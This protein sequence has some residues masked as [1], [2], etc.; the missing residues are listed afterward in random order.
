MSPLIRLGKL[1]DIQ[2][3]SGI[4][5][6]IAPSNLVGVAFS[7]TRIDLT[8]NDNSSDE[9]DFSIERAINGGSF[10]VI[11]TTAPNAT[12]YSDT[13]LDLTANYY[14]YRVRAH[15]GGGYS[16]YSNT[17]LVPIEAWINVASP[18]DKTTIELD[19]FT[20]TGT[21]AVQVWQ[22]TNGGA[23]FLNGT[24][25]VPAGA[26]Y[27]LVGVS[28][29]DLNTFKLK[30][31][32][33]NGTSYFGPTNFTW[34]VDSD[35]KNFATYAIGSW[36]GYQ[37]VEMNYLDEAV[38]M[39][40]GGSVATSGAASI[41]PI[42]PSACSNGDS[43]GAL[44]D[45]ARSDYF[46]Y[47]T[48]GTLT[49]RIQ[50]NYDGFITS[51]FN[52]QDFISYFGMYM[53]YF[54]VSMKIQLWQQPVLANYANRNNLFGTNDGVGAIELFGFNDAG[55]DKIGVI[56]PDAV[57]N[58]YALQKVTSWPHDGYVT[59]LAGFD[60]NSGDVS[61]SQGVTDFVDGTASNSDTN[62]P[63]YPYAPLIGARQE[64][65]GVFGFASFHMTWFVMTRGMTYADYLSFFY[66]Q[67][68]WNSN[69][70]R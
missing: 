7:A 34:A 59:G 63:G 1:K 42:S 18:F 36:G 57:P 2:K 67:D 29:N 52:M 39:L 66:A 55:T 15:N 27:I 44:W 35:A 17:I 16:A 25:S 3:A 11:F 60:I 56:S 46:G 6:P 23:Y 68:S 49:D 64:T 10:S 28:R 53:N 65:G 45:L 5:T 4:P 8:W 33:T 38:Q 69:V 30:S 51:Y 32:G 48:G 31:I 37:N 40:P 14:Q 9:T 47:L 58:Y 19:I 13:G 50:F 21:T 26:S 61:V 54:S 12:S 70:G 20:G 24:V 22:S 43:N 41:L 62:W